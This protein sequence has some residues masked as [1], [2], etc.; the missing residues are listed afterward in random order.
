MLQVRRQFYV[1]TNALPPLVGR[2]PGADRVLAKLGVAVAGAGSGA[3]VQP[4]S[5]QSFRAASCSDQIGHG[6]SRT[7]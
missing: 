3:V 1:S 4:C 7:D 6:R 2:P 5:G